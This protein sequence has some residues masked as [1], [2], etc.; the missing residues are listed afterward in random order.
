MR[1]IFPVIGTLAAAACAWAQQPAR[2]HTQGA[3][4]PAP[5]ELSLPQEAAPAPA[6]VVPNQQK[7][8]EIAETV[9]N[10]WR[11]AMMRADEQAWAGST[12]AARQNKIRNMVVSERKQFPKD[13]FSKQP[14]PPQLEHFAYVGSIAG[15][16]N[17]SMACTFIGK[18]QLGEK[19]KLAENAMVVELIFEGGKWK[20]DQT[21]FFNL[22]QLPDVKKRLHAQDLSVLQEQDGFHPY[23]KLPA[24]PPRCGA[25]QLIGK[26]FVDAPGREIEMRINGVSMH[27]FYDERRADT[28]AGGL[29]RGQNT[30][31]YTIKDN[32]GMQHPTLGIGL[33]VMP[34]TPGNHPVCVF[35]HILDAKDAAK[36]G[37]FTFTVSNEQIA[38]MNPKF[39][40]AKPEPFHVVPLKP[41]PQPQKEQ[42]K[43]K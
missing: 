17:R 36:G 26:V 40:R 5:R 41:K 43:G 1:A 42:P 8:R 34:E 22:S 19:G 2:T 20:L 33:F 27:E 18:L 3:P 10:T 25:P 32:A 28:I 11:L 35:D 39:Q 30:I 38:S 7:A 14:Q 9:Y 15:C 29:R 37:T 13:F 6:Y 21:R 24:I 16:G 12:S 31:S 4:I 23:D